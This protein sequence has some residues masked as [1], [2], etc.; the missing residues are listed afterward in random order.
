MSDF[1]Y[2]KVSLYGQFDN[3]LRTEMKFPS[4]RDG[5]PETK[6][7]VFNPTKVLDQFVNAR[8]CYA[9]WQTVNGC[10]YG[11]V[12][13]NPLD[14]ASGAMLLT[15]MVPHGVILSGRQVAN[16][17]SALR[18]TIVEEGKRSDE[19]II[20]TFRRAQ[21][22]V[23]PPVVP[24]LADRER[25]LQLPSDQQPKGTGYRTYMSS[26]ELDVI[27]SFPYQDD[28]RKFRRVLI[29]SATASLKPNAR[30]A[31]ITSGI[32]RAYWVQCPT[33]VTANSNFVTEGER[34]TLSFTKDGFNTTK[35]TITAGYPSPYIKYDGAVIIVKTPGESG[36]AF[37]KKIKINVRS[38]KGGV[39]NGY[40]INV[41]SRPINTMEPFIELTEKD[42]TEG[43]NIKIN[44]A[45]NNFQPMKIEKPAAELAALD[46]LDIV[47]EPLEQGILLRLDFGEGRL[48]EQRISIEKNT[49]EYSQLHSGNFHGFRAYR[50]TTQG[51]NETYN[52]DVRASCKPTAPAFDNVA[53]STSTHVV[54]PQPSTPN[55]STQTRR[56]PVFENI[57]RDNGSK[58]T[59]PDTRHD[60]DS[61]TKADDKSIPTFG[62]SD[63][64]NQNH[65]N[66]TGIIIG[67]VAAILLLVLAL[68]FFLP[69]STSTEETPE[70]TTDIEVNGSTVVA[71]E[72]TAP[73][74]DEQKP[75]TAQEATPAPAA[76]SADE[77]ADIAYLNN[78][79]VWD[80]SALKSEKYRS[81]IKAMRAGDIKAMAEH[82]YF[83][84]DGQAANIDARKAMDFA[85]AAL[86][87][88]NE[89]G[90]VEALK[91]L[92]AEDKINVHD[93]F[94]DLA[95]RQPKDKNQ[96]PR[97]KR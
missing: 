19:A 83:A 39:V 24:A 92:S 58:K 75:A 73:L 85:W 28:N 15:I 42:M 67:A 60:A 56:I 55:K 48:F 34:L 43:N 8:E 52:V 10:Y 66:K 94:E 88:D 93:L 5:E 84:V 26:H 64:E 70:K 74:A 51:A 53:S 16:T 50:L 18:K 2:I 71:N 40:T 12:T 3:E 97:P 90:N 23:N 46:T 1:S 69:T 38:A 7:T 87:S 21:L 32:K 30:I 25:H 35:E 57:S 11:M 17:L 59:T 77:Q 6:L 54:T 81:L 82:D 76:N 95:R 68:F 72:S 31:R 4:Q 29:V 63:S 44:I 78:N 9:L 13:R 91:K 49:P 89:K 79:K 37:V 86:N 96:T 41:N 61:I 47:L 80:V 14:P 45:S 62:N 22:P 65:K 36:L 20:E 27:L 33:G